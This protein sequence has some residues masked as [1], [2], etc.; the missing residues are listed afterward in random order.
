M[1]KMRFSNFFLRMSTTPA[2]E[3]SNK[4]ASTNKDQDQSPLNADT[5]S[6][7]DQNQDP[8][9]QI[10]RKRPSDND[11]DDTVPRKFS[12]VDERFD[13]SSK[14]KTNSWDIK[15]ELAEYAIKQMNSYING[16]DINDEILYQYPVPDNLN[17]KKDMDSNIKSLL[18]EMKAKETLSLDKAFESI[19]DKVLNIFGPFSQVWE[20][21]EIQKDNAIQQTSNMPKE[22]LT[23]EVKDMLRSAKDCSRL[24]DMTVTLLG[25]AF[26]TISYYRRRNALLSI[27]KGD[28]S[29]VKDMMKENKE[30]LQEDT[31][32]RLFGEK[33]DEKMV[34]FVKLKKKSREFF[35][36][37]DNKV[38]PSVNQQ[39]RVGLNQSFRGGPLPGPSGRGQNFFQSNQ[40]QSANNRIGKSNFFFIK[41]KF[42]TNF[43]SSRLSKGPPTSE[44]LVSGQVESGS[45][46]CR[47]GKIFHQELGKTDKGSLSAG[48]SSRLQNSI[49][50]HSTS[51]FFAQSRQ[52]IQGR[53]ETSGT[54]NRTNA[55]ER[56]NYQSESLQ[57][58]VFKQHF[59]SPQ[60]RWW[61]QTCNKPENV[62]QFHPLSSLQDGRT[63]SN[64]RIAFTERLVGEG[65]FERCLFLYT[66]PAE[67][68]EI[69][70]FRMGRFS[71]S[72]H[73]LMLWPIS[74]SIGVHK[75][76][77]S[78]YN[79][80]K[81]TSD[82]VNHIPRRHTSNGL[83]KGGDGNSQGYVDF[84]ITTPRLRDQCEKVRID[85]N[86][87]NRVS[88]SYNRLSEDG[89][90]P[91]RGKN[92]KD[93]FEMF[94]NVGQEK[95]HY[96][97]SFPT[98]RN[99][100]INNDGCITSS[101]PVQIPPKTSDSGI[102][103]LPLVRERN[104][105]IPSGQSRNRMVDKQ[106][107]I[108]QWKVS[109]VE[110]PSTSNKVRCLKGGLGGLLSGEKNWG[111]LVRE[112]ARTSDINT[113]RRNR[114]TRSPCV[115]SQSLCRADP[116]NYFR[117]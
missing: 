45:T 51:N 12:K 76:F 105:F 61:E 33:F 93:H 74:C 89:N 88:G 46:T 106:H 38:K 107:K 109:S 19:Q 96:K 79:T 54:G 82:Q 100:I 78:S 49:Y 4:T 94:K 11:S 10:P 47:E 85:S 13:L 43:V 3:E 44:K 1:S 87:D 65:R 90:V 17:N 22:E 27:L 48:D 34:E 56:G 104:N 99:I 86:K 69:L 52:L 81:K 83:L 36:V 53:K 110:T 9:V 24:M 58:P 28:K 102:K 77:E 117:H 5:A 60:K 41:N 97:R 62:E 32:N 115:Y 98:D 14:D 30:I 72:V 59:H 7:K 50:K 55:R 15:T 111:S 20:F 29:K 18:T 116:S 40:S 23:D 113:R 66:H 16:N 8:T 73:Q 108:E 42:S 39:T 80:F 21:L 26:N 114:T 95:G 91:I 64:K 84:S 92:S 67:F 2:S 63:F 75:T 112:R 31:S 35:N 70:T 57:R 101:T 6:P 103:F 25:Q 71:L 37:M 68:T